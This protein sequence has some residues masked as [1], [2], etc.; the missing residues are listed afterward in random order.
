M[1]YGYINVQMRRACIPSANGHFSARALAR[2][3]GTLANGGS[4]DGIRLLS[5]GTVKAMAHTAA[6]ES[7]SPAVREMLSRLG[8]RFEKASIGFVK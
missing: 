6:T 8:I 5:E 3:F 1:G 4:I 2:F 7:S